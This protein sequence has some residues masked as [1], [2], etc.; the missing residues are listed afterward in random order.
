[1]NI[2]KHPL[3]GSF[4]EWP[5]FCVF[6]DKPGLLDS[7]RVAPSAR[8]SPGAGEVE[9]IVKSVALNFQE[10]LYALGAM[11]PPVG[12]VTLGLECAG[13]ITRVGA[14]V[15]D[16]RPGMEVIAIGGPCLS[17]YVTLNAS[18]V[19]SKPAGLSWEEAAG[20]SIA[21]LTAQYSLHRLANLRLGESVLIHAAAGGVGLAAL[22]VA[23]S[24]GATVFAT[25]GSAR[26][27]SYLESR[28]ICKI[29]DSRTLSFAEEIM[30]DTNGRGV[31]VV[32]NCLAGE[33]IIKGLSVLAP[34]GRF[35]ELGKRDILANMPIPFGLLARGISLMV[36]NFGIHTPGFREIF[37]CLLLDV[38]RGLLAPPACQTFAFDDLTD[39]MHLMAR[40]EHIGKV[41][42][43]LPGHVSSGALES[44]KASLAATAGPL[45][46]DGLTNSEGIDIFRR[47]I[48]DNRAQLVVSTT[49][50]AAVA[51]TPL[52]H[53]VLIPRAADRAMTG[54]SPRPYL[55]SG[56]SAP[57]SDLERSLCSAWEQFLRIDQIGIHDNF[58]DLGG[59]S[60]M[61][62]QLTARIRER[63]GVE[64]APHGLLEHPTIAS[65]AE[66]LRSGSTT[67]H[68]IA[69]MPSSLVKLK[70]G[71]PARPLFLIF[72]AGGLVYL[73][74]ALAN[75]ITSPHEIYGVQSVFPD[76]QNEG[77]ET[78]EAMAQYYREQI[79]RKQPTGPY[80]IGGAS[81]GGALAYEIAQQILVAGH[82]VQL[83]FLIDTPDPA[84]APTGDAL[85]DAIIMNDALHARTR[86]QSALNGTEHPP[87]R[88]SSELSLT[89]HRTRRNVEA[90]A[91]YR[92]GPFPGALVYFRAIDQGEGFLDT[93]A[94]SWS[95]LALKAGEVHDIPGNHTT[96][97]F[98]PHVKVMGNKL[99]RV[100]QGVDASDSS[101][102]SSIAQ[103]EEQ[104]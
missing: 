46:L 81:F 28:G 4:E 6:V 24:L 48:S 36:V 93:R 20:V 30:A 103:S 100:L 63:L 27:R 104:L 19:A 80:L 40:G 67:S 3:L 73:Y 99:T 91:R 44:S 23:K 79:C 47:A 96:M 25:T 85:T 15:L 68:A 21:Y 71:D 54:M 22:E 97:N 95:R 50:L 102:G 65:L 55:A 33:Y 43:N 52:N 60:L 57:R 70:A 84:S 82:Q 42:I 75:A 66:K 37:D 17:R 56:Y 72:P 78:M 74:G 69:V 101:G 86:L 1:M 90:L 32:L 26:K 10:I 77:P 49:P 11:P 14:D 51:A 31:D 92:P 8:R 41:V 29:Y 59:D 39:A 2:S 76:G 45:P 98:M 18:A 5:N 87:D 83:L 7:L 34:F 9:V 88:S 94:T 64:L 58:F 62:L 38:E 89:R 53:A 12:A 35:L 61:A 16:L 13:V